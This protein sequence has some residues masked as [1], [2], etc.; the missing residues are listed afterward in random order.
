MLG[1]LST[2]NQWPAF[3]VQY[4]VLAFIGCISL[5]SL[6]GFLRNMRK[7]GTCSSPAMPVSF[8]CS[9]VNRP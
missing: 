2:F 8:L 1:V 3:S 5:T 6:R 9:L 4:I 7:V